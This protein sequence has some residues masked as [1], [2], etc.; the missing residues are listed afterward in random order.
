MQKLIASSPSATINLLGVDIGCILDTGAETSL[1][2]N[3]TYGTHLK[4]R[5]GGKSPEGIYIPIVGANGKPIDVV[6]YV[7]LPLKYGS[8]VVKSSFLVTKDCSGKRRE[9]HPFLLGCNNLRLLKQFNVPVKDG[10]AW[11]FVQRLLADEPTEK[12]QSISSEV[13]ELKVADNVTLPACSV[14]RVT[15]SVGELKGDVMVSPVAVKSGLEVVE[16]CE[17]VGN[18]VVQIMVA[19]PEK[20]S[21]NLQSG[22]TIGSVTTVNQESRVVLKEGENSSLK[23]CVNEVLKVSGDVDKVVQPGMQDERLKIDQDVKPVPGLNLSHLNDEDKHRVTDCITNYPEAFSMSVYDVGEC[24]VIPHNISLTSDKAIKLPFRRIYAQRVPEVKKMIQEMVDQKIIRPS[25]S[26]YASPVVLVTKKGG[27]LRL[28]IDYRKLNSMTIKDSFP[29]PR[30]EEVLD[31]LGGA[32]FFSALDL[33]HGYHQ[34]TLEDTSI[35]KTAF[36]VPWGLY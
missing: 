34:I 33:A 5:L 32:R 26:P 17:T 14:R 23:I 20:H 13:A 28:V 1:I 25:K 4:P 29:L 24:D 21:I 30:I 7:E 36:S 9:N 12:K 15:C 35:K 3:E 10:F 8:D 19:N 16:G 27:S 18:G 11:Q 22:S 6:G 2:P 31:L